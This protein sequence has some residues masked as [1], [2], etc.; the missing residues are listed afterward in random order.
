MNYSS[1]DHRDGDDDF[2][3]EILSACLF[4]IAPMD[5]EQEM[6]PSTNVSH[7]APL[8]CNS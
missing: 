7:A 3:A 4:V 1:S 8:L 2:K 6:E 5:I